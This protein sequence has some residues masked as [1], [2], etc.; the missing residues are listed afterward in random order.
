MIISERRKEIL[1]GTADNVTT[2]ELKKFLREARIYCM[3]EIETTLRSRYWRILDD[4]QSRLCQKL[5]IS[6]SEHTIVRRSETGLLL[7]ANINC[8]FIDDYPDYVYEL[9]FT[10]NSPECATIHTVTRAEKFL[11]R[12]GNDDA[13]LL[14]YVKCEKVC[15]Q[16]EQ[17]IQDRWRRLLIRNGI[18]ADTE[19][20][21]LTRTRIDGLTFPQWRMFNDPDYNPS[22]STF[23]LMK[24]YFEK[25]GKPE[26]A[27]FIQS[28]YEE[29][30][31]N[32]TPPPIFEILSQNEAQELRNFF[33]SPAFRQQLMDGSI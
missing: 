19:Y 2:E 23:V 26:K 33:L 17:N 32:T 24:Q 21:T 28:R 8:F 5:N 14:L 1:K 6:P 15:N 7:S 29:C 10:E 18:P 31:K 3:C 25:R 12:T 27:A 11:K 30:L 16:I 9:L 13:L 22:K 4:P 20:E